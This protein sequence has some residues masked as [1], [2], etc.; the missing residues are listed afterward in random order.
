MKLYGSL[1]NYISMHRRHIGLS[2][3]ELAA[4]VAVENRGS[5]ARYELG[6]RLPE[7]ETL[8]RLEVVLGTPVREL[9]AGIAERMREDVTQRARALLEGMGDA[10]SGR[11]LMKLDTLSKL[12]HPND[13][14]IIPIWEDPA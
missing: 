7:L 12:A 14:R 3:A 4:L 6:V 10:P 9:F 2:Q 5:V 1:D 13:I 8:L 11:A